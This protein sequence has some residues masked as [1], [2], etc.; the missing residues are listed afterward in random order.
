MQVLWYQGRSASALTPEYLHGLKKLRH[1]EG[2]KTALFTAGYLNAPAKMLIR[3][4]TIED[5]NYY[6]ECTFVYESTKLKTARYMF[7]K[8]VEDALQITFR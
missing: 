8:D 4:H 7:I 2:K 5:F 6:V 1:W 3:K